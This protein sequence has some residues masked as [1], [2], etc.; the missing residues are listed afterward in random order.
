[1]KWPQ[2]LSRGWVNI[3]RVSN[4]ALREGWGDSSHL[5]KRLMYCVYLL[6]SNKDQRFYIGCSSDIKRRFDEHKNGK[7]QSTK[8]RRPL[9]LI[10]FEAYSSEK[11]AR[12]REFQLKK[13]G[14]AYTG[15]LKRLGFK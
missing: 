10:Y 8:H 4:P 14:S 3:T 9:Q 13:F 7:V 12:V 5:D 11:K 6:K 2:P 1:M 15:L